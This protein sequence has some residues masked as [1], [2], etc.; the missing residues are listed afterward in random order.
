MQGHAEAVFN[1]SK[2]EEYIYLGPSPC[3]DLHFGEELLKEG[4]SAVISL[5]GEKNFAPAGVEM[6]LWFPTEDGSAPTMDQIKLGI[7]TIDELVR[8]GKKVYV[9]C[10]FGMGRAP[11]LVAAHFIKHGLSV[12]EAVSYIKRTRSN[13][14]ITQAQ[15]DILSEYEEHVR[16]KMIERV[17]PERQFPL[18]LKERIEK[19]KNSASTDGVPKRFMN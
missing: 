13:F 2:V 6:Y 8:M 14:V 1:W 7:R 12:S 19:S 5:E 18:T 4:I 15:Y 10:R 11:T 3:C 9:H 16:T 17:E